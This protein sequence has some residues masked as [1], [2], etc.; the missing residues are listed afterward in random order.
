MAKA[1]NL[2]RDRA[3]FLGMLKTGQAIVNVKQRHNDSFLIDTPFYK[4]DENVW[5]EE[6]KQAMHTVSKDSHTESP[7]F[8]DSGVS[9][10]YQD[11]ETTPP[12]TAKKVITGLEKCFLTNISERPFD[13][14]DARS[15]G[16]GLHPSQ[17]TE[18]HNSLGNK[19]I[20]NPVQIGNLKLFEITTKG[21]MIAEQC[22]I[23]I[24]KQ[25]SR[26]GIEHAFAI[27]QTIRFLNKLDFQPACEVNDIDIADEGPSIAIEIET[28]KSNI[29]GNLIKLEKSRF[30][31]LFMLATNK[32]AEFKIKSKAID[33]PSIRFMHVKDFLKLTK[34]QILS[35]Q[36]QSHPKSEMS[37]ITKQ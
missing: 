34:N 2:E 31:K 23:K 12:T 21:R 28:G 26:G 33:F 19:G 16:L 13:G 10:L 25:D 17:M 20:I 14:V 8:E 15:K 4:E 24:K 9:H 11:N 7:A 22:G 36:S 5:D 18:L 32:V 3:R 1:M 27:H 37:A 29:T 6:L 35:N 30:E